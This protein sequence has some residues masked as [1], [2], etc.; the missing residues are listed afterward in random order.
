M[1]LMGAVL[2]GLR[3]HQIGSHDRPTAAK[4]ALAAPNAMNSSPDPGER[5]QT[6]ETGWPEPALVEEPTECTYLA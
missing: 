4:E 6:T 2:V 5:R 3:P 1:I